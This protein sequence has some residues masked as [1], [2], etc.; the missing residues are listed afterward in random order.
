MRRRSGFTLIEVMVALVVSGIV[1]VGARAMLEV[2]AD[3][4]ASITAAAAAADRDANAERTLRALV[5]RIEVGNGSTTDFAGD[6]AA[7]HLASW[8]DVPGGWQEQ[9]TVT[10][11][12]ER[13][14]ARLA[15]VARTSLGDVFVLRTGLR[16]GALRYLV[17]PKAGGAWIRGWGAGITAPLA[18]GI[19]TDRDTMIVRIGERG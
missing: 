19:F 17:D 10:L 11:G 4:A 13:D 15:L 12:F 9:C 7:A 6:S 2:T 14:G 18:I 8:C 16:V 1:L 3:R 5:E